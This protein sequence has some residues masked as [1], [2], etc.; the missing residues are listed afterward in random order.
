MKGILIV[1]HG[2][3]D[4]EAKARSLDRLY[5]ESLHLA[6]V[7][8]ECYVSQKILAKEGLSLD[9]AMKK[10]CDLGVDDLHVYN[11][12]IVPGRAYKQFLK[13]VI[14]YST[15]FRHLTLEK[16]LLNEQTD[17]SNLARILAKNYPIEADKQYVLVGHGA[18]AEV[19]KM[20]SR[21]EAAFLKLDYTQVHFAL[22]RGHPAIEDLFD[23]LDP[24]KKVIVCPLMMSAGHHVAHDVKDD[25]ESSI[26][27]KLIDAHFDVEVLD[28]GLLEYQDIRDLIIPKIDR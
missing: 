14:P 3:F 19:N 4:H 15:F 10:M 17:F 28:Q 20:Y 5:Q 27:R 9:D 24:K 13:T 1:H 12:L 22:L 21:L 25:Q 18:D 26:E 8:M 7:V 6:D 16:P 11:S 2:T 23:V